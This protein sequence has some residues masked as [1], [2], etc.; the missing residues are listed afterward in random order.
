MKRIKFP[1][2]V[3]NG[4][5][6]RDL[7]ELRE[8]FDIELIMIYFYNGKLITWLEDRDYSIELE[9]IKS[10]KDSHKNLVEKLCKIFEVKCSNLEL[11]VDRIIEK[12]KKIAY[13]KQFTEDTL[14]LE[15]IEKIAFDDEEL[16]KLVNERKVTNGII[17]DKEASDRDGVFGKIAN[18]LIGFKLIKEPI[19]I[20][21]CGEKFEIPLEEENITYIGVN[22]AVALINAEKLIDFE[23]LNIKFIN[24]EFNKKYKDI[25]KEYDV[26]TRKNKKIIEKRYQQ[27]LN[28]IEEI[29]RRTSIGIEHS[30]DE[31]FKLQKECRE[32]LLDFKKEAINGEKNFGEIA[33]QMDLEQVEIFLRS[34]IYFEQAKYIME[35]NY[36]KYIESMNE[37]K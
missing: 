9:K 16:I 28:K 30:F 25:M 20:H 23:K 12:H 4:V 34:S 2:E 17:N 24:M 32:L 29:N 14:I 15:K 3:A 1:L 13:L 37:G 33:F 8:N 36:F 19:E 7:D 6:A 11:D 31:E 27:I 5:R 10:L 18:M 22:K 35:R 26:G 21:V